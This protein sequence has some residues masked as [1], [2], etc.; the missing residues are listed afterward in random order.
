MKFRTHHRVV[1]RTYIFPAATSAR[2]DIGTNLTHVDSPTIAVPCHC[3]RE[4]ACMPPGPLPGPY[5]TPFRLHAHAPAHCIVQA[6]APPEVFVGINAE[7]RCVVQPFT[8]SR[9][10]LHCIINSE[11]LP[12]PDVRYNPLGRFALYP[13]RV[14]RNGRLATC[15]HVG[16]V[17]HDCFLRVR[18]LLQPC[19]GCPASHSRIFV[20]A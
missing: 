8:S 14:V 1:E 3:A 9:N 10:R 15:W 19:T 6:F 16:G 20:S 17:N 5:A 18:G 4:V 13:I 12:P 11:G 2:Y 7:A